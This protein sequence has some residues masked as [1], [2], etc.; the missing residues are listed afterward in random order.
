M[1]Q[2]YLRTV[3]KQ[4][5][6]RPT[7]AI[8][9]AVVALFCLVGIYAPFLASSKPIVVVYDGT[10]YFPLFRYL[11]YTGFYT[12][13]IDIFFNLLIFTFPFIVLGFWRRNKWILGS[14]ITLQ[15]V[16][17]LYFGYRLPQDPAADPELNRARQEAIQNL[18]E[19]PTWDFYLDYM[20]DYRKLNLLIRYRNLKTQNERLQQYRAPFQ[21]AAEKQWLSREV[22]EQRLQMLRDGIPPSQIPSYAELQK[23]VLKETPESVKEIRLAMPTLWN[24]REKRILQQTDRLRETLASTSPDSRE[25]RRAQ[26]ELNDIEAERQWYQIQSEK[27]SFIL[28]PLLRDFHWEDDAGGQQNLNQYISWYER[29]RI[30][31][32]D[33]LAALV[34]GVRISLVVGLLA[35]TLALII[36]VPIGSIAGYYAGK[37]DIIVSRLLEIWESMPVFFMLLLVVAITQSKSIFIVI[38]V[39]GLFGWT[40]FSRYIRGEFFKQRNLPYVEACY[41][42]GF[43]DRYIIFNHILPNAIPPL[44]TLLPFAVMAAITSEA[45][46]SFLGL[47]EEGSA[48]WGVLMDEGRAA[49]PGES[50]LLWPPAILLTVLLI[51]IALVGDALRDALDPKMHR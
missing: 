13:H 38:S 9:L 24:M 28:M 14:A 19:P 45:A 4:F 21:E 41:A 22:R 26:A 39:I 37:T 17:F 42:Q 48:S 44:L 30:N 5:L 18:D 3:R 16:L 34:F 2:A 31:R 12:K 36:G 7:A 33:M 49:F 51:S 50:Y 46:L 20:T 27:I 23:I 1:N 15:L 35:V 25:H 40:S 11:F 10:V 47:G 29:T 43:K 32:K 8:A 6:K